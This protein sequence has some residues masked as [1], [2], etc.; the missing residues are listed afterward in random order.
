[1]DS[2]GRG[3]PKWMTSTKQNGKEGGGGGRGPKG[4]EDRHGKIGCYKQEGVRRKLYLIG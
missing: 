1:M 3:G 2:E 4:H